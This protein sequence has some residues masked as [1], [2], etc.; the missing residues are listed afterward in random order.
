[1]ANSQPVLEVRDLVITSYSIHYTKLYEDTGLLDSFTDIDQRRLKILGEVENLKNKRNVASKE[2]ARLKKGS[3]EDKAK[4]EPMI[5]EMR[6]IGQTIKGL[7]TELAEIEMQLQDIVM[8]IPNLCDD[9]V[10]KGRNNF[11]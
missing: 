10:P 9:S 6:D 5:L 3:A 1:M 2:I 8:S 4:A 7:D 11:V